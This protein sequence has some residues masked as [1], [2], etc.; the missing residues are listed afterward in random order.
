LI[1]VGVV[2]LL[3]VSGVL[4]S[5]WK[6]NCLNSR[7]W[8]RVHQLDD[9]WW[10]VATLLGDHN[11]A[12]VMTTDCFVFCSVKRLI[13]ERVLGTGRQSV[14]LQVAENNVYEC[15]TAAEAEAPP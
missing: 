6:N 11:Q 1:S 8:R 2:C 5:Y 4:A 12:L 10:Q 13:A 7:A 3:E 9:I 14:G 15:N